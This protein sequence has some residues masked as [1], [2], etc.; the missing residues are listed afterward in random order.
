MAVFFTADTHF[1]SKR[2]LELS[3]RP[4]HDVAEMDNSIIANWNNFVSREDTVYHLGDLGSFDRLSRLNGKLFFLPGNYDDIDLIKA[5]AARGEIVEPNIVI[6][7]DGHTFQLVH[8]PDEALPSQHFFL[9]GH[10]HKLQMVKRNGL[11]VGVDCHNFA[12]VSLETVLFYQNAIQ[13][14]YDENV[15]METLGAK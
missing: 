11:N 12:P 6:T 2:I 4:F 15:F 7:V 10:I 13:T 9:F 1:G 5:I 3:K 8:K 14:N